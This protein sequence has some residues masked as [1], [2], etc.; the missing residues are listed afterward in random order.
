MRSN[1]ASIHARF[2]CLMHL[3]SMPH[4]TR[5]HAENIDHTAP[6]Q[7][8]QRGTASQHMVVHD[9]ALQ[10]TTHG[11]TARHATAR[12]STRP[13]R[14]KQHSTRPSRYKQLSIAHRSAVPRCTALH[15]TAHHCTAQHRTTRHSTAQH[16][17][18]HR[19]SHQASRRATSRA[20]VRPVHCMHP[21][22]A[23]TSTRHTTSKSTRQSHRT[24]S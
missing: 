6:P 9:L 16:S 23:V 13:S 11:A 8:T 1:N 20:A 22:I 19:R 17:T 24:L 18:S 2:F 3:A 15:C 4:A 14:Y 21:S 5:S 7:T 10:H 12:H